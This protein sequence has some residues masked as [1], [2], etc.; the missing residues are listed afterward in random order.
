MAICDADTATA[1]DVGEKRASHEPGRLVA[2]PLT[3]PVPARGGERGR[4]PSCLRGGRRDGIS[5]NS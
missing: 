3:A 5:G 2:P 4:E 1:G